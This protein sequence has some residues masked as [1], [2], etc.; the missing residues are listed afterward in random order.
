MTTTER[1][2]TEFSAEL[3]RRGV[4]PTRIKRESAAVREHVH[5]SR[6]AAVDCFGDPVA[7]AASIAP[8]ADDDTPS[9]TILIALFASIALFIVFSLAAVRWV[10]G[11]ASA[12]AW[13]IPAGAGLLA[14]VASLSVS[15]SRRAVA[16]AL[17]DAVDGATDRAWRAG[18]I[19]LFTLPWAFIAF[20]A[21]VTVLAALL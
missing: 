2:I 11:D 19:L 18:S 5:E 3:E 8:P 6:H 13:A 16:T 20:A 12:A 10:D 14:A 17:R 4:E 9:A 7:Y 1:W 21:A 15:I